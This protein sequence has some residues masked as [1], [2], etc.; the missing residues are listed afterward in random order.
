VLGLLTLQEVRTATAPSAAAEL[1]LSAVSHIALA[2]TLA[3]ADLD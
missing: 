2:V 3:S 1:C